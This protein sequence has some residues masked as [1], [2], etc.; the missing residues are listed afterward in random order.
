MLDET[1]NHAASGG[2]SSFRTDSPSRPSHFT[3]APLR[4]IRRTNKLR[5]GSDF[6]KVSGLGSD[7]IRPQ[8]LIPWGT[9]GGPGPRQPS[10][11]RTRRGRRLPLVTPCRRRQRKSDIRP[12]PMSRSRKEHFLGKLSRGTKRNKRPS[13]HSFL[14]GAR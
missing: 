7:N 3:D 5:P 2:W 11:G 1:T 9:S 4:A 12:C 10:R 6:P 13:G 8:L 14:E